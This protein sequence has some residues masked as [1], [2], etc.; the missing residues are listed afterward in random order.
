MELR[1]PP[2]ASSAF[3]CVL[4]CV[5]GQLP[6]VWVQDSVFSWNL[7]LVSGSQCSHK[8]YSTASWVAPKRDTQ[9]ARPSGVVVVP[10]EDSCVPL[11]LS[12]LVV[13]PRVALLSSTTCYVCNDSDLT[14]KGLTD[15]MGSESLVFPP[16]ILTPLAN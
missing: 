4:L 7:T 3:R 9:K 13:A 1:A 8:S 14:V 10:S 5:S 16:H 11:A 6:K 15:I 2:V 12:A